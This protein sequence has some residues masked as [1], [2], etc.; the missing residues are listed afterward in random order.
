MK[1]TVEELKGL[2]VEAY[3]NQIIE[4][5]DNMDYARTT[6]SHNAKQLEKIMLNGIKWDLYYN[7]EPQKQ[8]KW[9]QKYK[10]LSKSRLLELEEEINRLENDLLFACNLASAESNL[11]IIAEKKEELNNHTDLKE[12]LYKLKEEFSPDKF[13][14]FLDIGVKI[15]NQSKETFSYKLTET[16]DFVEIQVNIYHF[17][18]MFQSHL[19]YDLEKFQRMQKVNTNAT[20]TVL[21]EATNT[22]FRFIDFI[23]NASF[24]REFFYNMEVVNEFATISFYSHVAKEDD[25]PRLFTLPKQTLGKTQFTELAK[26]LFE[27]NILQYN[28]E[29]QAVDVLSKALNVD[30][31]KPEFDRIL[32]K[33]KTRNTE[34]ETKFLDELSTALKSWINKP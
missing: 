25:K 11:K 21:K 7:S 34:S 1:V 4:T 31:D 15:C 2:N 26:S 6:I 29:K 33:I 30:I 24:C 20:Q 27:A 17:K 23:Q 3:I 28:T 10:K 16:I 18:K 12:E 22:E 9:H 5:V 13:K 19:E 8:N 14:Q 32:Q